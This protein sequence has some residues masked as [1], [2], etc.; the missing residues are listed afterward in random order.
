MNH[1]W[2]HLVAGGVKGEVLRKRCENCLME[3]RQVRKGSTKPFGGWMEIHYRMGNSG[4][5]IV[6]RSGFKL[7]TCEWR[8]KCPTCDGTGSITLD[9]YRKTH[10]KEKEGDQG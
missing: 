1:K 3:V 8:K 10:E 2:K 5:W 4:K 6:K 7:P 9:E